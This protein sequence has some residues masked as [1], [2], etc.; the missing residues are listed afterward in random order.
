VIPECGHLPQIERP[1]R[2][3]DALGRVLDEVERLTDGAEKSE[4]TTRKEER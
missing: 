2:F 1:D 3:A 4:N